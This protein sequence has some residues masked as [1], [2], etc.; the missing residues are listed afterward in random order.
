MT[1]DPKP[2][3]KKAF[4]EECPPRKEESEK[5]IE[6]QCDFFEPDPVAESHD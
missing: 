4:S 3:N 6:E 2:L 5:K 1:E